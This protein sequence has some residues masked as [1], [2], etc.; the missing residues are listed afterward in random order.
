M[1]EELRAKETE[2]GGFFVRDTVICEN[3]VMCVPVMFQRMKKNVKIKNV[4]CPLDFYISG[5]E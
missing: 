2:S 4:I 3:G 5:G 1:D